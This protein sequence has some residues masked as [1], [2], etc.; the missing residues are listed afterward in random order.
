MT[1][2]SFE[3]PERLAPILEVGDLLL[4]EAL[5]VALGF[6]RQHDYEGYLILRKSEQEVHLRAATSPKPGCVYLRVLDVDSAYDALRG[7]AGA[8]LSNITQ[9]AYLARE[10]AATDAW[11]NTLR[12]AQAVGRRGRQSASAPT[13]TR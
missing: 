7:V 1:E 2:K 13:A 9:T 3:P 6:R 4:G 12:V 11:G 8:T 5:F 10:F